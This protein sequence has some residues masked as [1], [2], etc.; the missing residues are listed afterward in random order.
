MKRRKFTNEEKV[1][2]LEEASKNGVT[3]TLEHYGI[4]PA[5]YYAWKKKYT[6]MGEEGFA[7][8]MTP[9]QLKRIREL[10]KENRLLKELVAEK[11][12]EGKFNNELQKKKYDLQERKNS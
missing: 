12:L 10:E 7:H 5:T 2:I 6:S 9:G 11:E 1:K 4:Y 3:T 8:G